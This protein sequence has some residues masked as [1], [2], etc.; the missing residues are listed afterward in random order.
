MGEVERGCGTWCRWAYKVK[1]LLWLCIC[2]S[3]GIEG[4][5]GAADVATAFEEFADVGGEYCEATHFEL[6]A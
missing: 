5:G 1:G 2:L 6:S 4:E 3:V